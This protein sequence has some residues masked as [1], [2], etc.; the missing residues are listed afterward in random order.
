MNEFGLIVF[1]ALVN[2]L[3]TGLVGGVIVDRYKKDIDDKYNK[4]M[5]EFNA[6]LQRLSF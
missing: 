3:I 2:F 1:T 6:N 5:A 4:Q